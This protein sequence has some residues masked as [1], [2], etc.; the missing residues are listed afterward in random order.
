[1][2]DGPLNP[3]SFTPEEYN[4]YVLSQIKMP[5]CDKELITTVKWHK[6]DINGKPIGT[7]NDN[8]LLD[9]R[10]YK[11]DMPDGT[12]EEL[13]VNSISENLFAQYDEDRFMYQILDK[14][15]DHCTNGQAISTDDAYI[16]TPSGRNFRKPRL[17]GSCAVNGNT[18]KPLG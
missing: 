4:Q 16:D 8:P 6:R 5:L 3:D 9:T 12:V 13:V 15:V 11:V 2:T 17:V 18:E 1:M 10:L 7:S 14:I